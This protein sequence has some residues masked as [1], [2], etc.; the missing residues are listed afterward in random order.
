MR[1]IKVGQMN[2]IQSASEGMVPAET[3]GK[4]ISLQDLFE[5]GNMF[6]KDDKLDQAETVFREILKIAPDHPGALHFLGVIARQCGKLESAVNLIKKAIKFSP[7]YHTAHNNLGQTYRDIGDS[8][9]AK[10]AFNRAIEENP[11]YA[12]AHFNLS[13]IEFFDRAYK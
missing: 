11:D 13:L 2:Q 8:E 6:H 9:K 5:L 7:T 3:S 12:L 4:Q 10:E 1:Y